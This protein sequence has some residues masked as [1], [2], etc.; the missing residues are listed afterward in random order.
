[1]VAAQV[2]TLRCCRRCCRSSDCS[3]CAAPSSVSALQLMLVASSS[4]LSAPAMMRAVVWRSRLRC[5]RLRAR[6]VVAE[7]GCRKEKAGAVLLLRMWW[8]LLRAAAG[9]N[10]LE[11]LSTGVDFS[12]RVVELREKQRGEDAF[13]VYMLSPLRLALRPFVVWCRTCDGFD[14]VLLLW[15]GR[16]PR[17]RP[18]RASARGFSSCCGRR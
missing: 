13:D 9:G 16:R 11:R 7:A 12:T 18:Q 14:V 5:S 3:D 8:C 4:P 6:V 17:P 2:D 1:M 15:L 10:F